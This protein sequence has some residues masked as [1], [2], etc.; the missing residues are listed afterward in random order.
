MDQANAVRITPAGLYYLNYLCGQF[1]YIDLIQQDTPIFD[2]DIYTILEKYS[3]STFMDDRFKRCR[4]F[5]DYL[6]I[7]EKNEK[8]MID[9][10]TN[11]DLLTYT[12]MSEIFDKYNRTMEK[13]Q[14]KYKID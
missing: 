7:Q 10:I 5:L 1:A 8:N 6:I 11:N 4:E 9:K 3:E 2:E 13:I 12:F 14:K